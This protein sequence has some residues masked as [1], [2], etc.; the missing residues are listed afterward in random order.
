MSRKLK[1]LTGKGEIHPVVTSDN[2]VDKANLCC[3][4]E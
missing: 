2:E 3:A 1:G 4:I